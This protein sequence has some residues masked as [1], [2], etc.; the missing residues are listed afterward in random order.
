MLGG[1]IRIRDVQYK[2]WEHERNEKIRVSLLGAER[3][4]KTAC[5][6]SGE[7]LSGNDLRSTP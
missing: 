7:T 1:T 3:K 2:V 4:N 6:K 5:L